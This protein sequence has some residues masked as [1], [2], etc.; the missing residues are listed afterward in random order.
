M[1]AA[2]A[3]LQRLRTDWIDLYQVH[4]PDPQTPIE[5]TLRALDDL[6]RQGKVRHVGCSNFSAEE[7]VAAQETAA[8]L[9]LAS[10]VTAQDEYSLLERGIERDLLPVIEKHGMSLL[11]YF[12]LASGFLTG[13]YKRGAPP[14]ANARLAG[15]NER[16]INE[17]TWR[18]VEQLG[19]F[20]ARRGHTMVEL[21]F[22]W[23]LAKPV[24]A[25][26]IAGATKPQQVEENV[27]AAT[28]WT[29]S[30]DD[31]AEVDRITAMPD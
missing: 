27:R 11:P 25:S 6:V 3:S 7:V 1:A 20:C 26:V 10:F 24:I 19:D 30:P 15:G 16:F 21:A 23:L 12:P 31:I 13:K 17:R 5:E 22:A 14:P 2:E 9:G 8:R 4:R 29:L 28:A 18:I